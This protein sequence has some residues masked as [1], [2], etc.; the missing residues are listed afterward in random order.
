MKVICFKN[1]VWTVDCC[2]VLP[3]SVERRTCVV[4]PLACGVATHAREAVRNVAILS[5]VNTVCGG[6]TLFHWRPPSEV[7]SFACSPKAQPVVRLIM[8]RE[9]KAPEPAASFE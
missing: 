8:C 4:F 3:P 6:L 2:Q 1:V 9:L 5:R 7:R